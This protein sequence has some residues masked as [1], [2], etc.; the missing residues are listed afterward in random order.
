MAALLAEARRQLHQHRFD[1]K[2][3]TISA[4]GI[5]SPVKG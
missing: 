2:A 5:A 1:P 3:L 4:S